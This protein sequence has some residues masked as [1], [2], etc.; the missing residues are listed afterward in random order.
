MVKQKLLGSNYLLNLQ[1]KNNL[2]CAKIRFSNVYGNR[3]D[4]FDR[5]I[6]KFIRAVKT[7]SILSI[8]GGDQVIDFTHINDTIHFI[9]TVI[10]YLNTNKNIQDNFHCCPGIGWSLQE[11]IHYIEIAIGKKANL[12]II[13]KRNYDVVKFVGDTTKIKNRLGLNHFI[14]LEEGIS[15]SI[16]EYCYDIK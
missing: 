13:P 1:K 10:E 7:D 11:L 12:K 4:I 8:E 15:K 2:N 16:N 3:F 5:V 9:L 6:P 14:S